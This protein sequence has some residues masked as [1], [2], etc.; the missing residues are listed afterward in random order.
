MADKLFAHDNP[1]LLQPAKNM[2]REMTEAERV[3]WF[4]LRANR[5]GGYKFRRQQPL[6]AYIADFVCTRPKLIIE[7][8]SGQHTEQ[9]AYDNTRSK[10][11]EAQGFTVL[12]FWN[13]EILQQTAAVLEQIFQTLQALSKKES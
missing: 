4:H 10:W 7:A 1:L 12:R 2:R 5:L 13:H 11:F 9:T 8:D 3:L 6:G